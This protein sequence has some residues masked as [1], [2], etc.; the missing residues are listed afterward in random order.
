MKLAINGGTPI[1][2]KLFPNQVNIENEE[3]E[4]VKRVMKSEMLSGY[5]GNAK[6]YLGR[7]I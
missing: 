3:L 2:T 5:R 4:A 7:R 1:R 6:N